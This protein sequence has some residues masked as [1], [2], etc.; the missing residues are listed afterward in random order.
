MSSYCAPCQGIIPWFV[1][2]FKDMKWMSRL[3]GLEPI[4][5]A[6]HQNLSDLESASQAGCP[7]CG[8]IFNL[9]TEVQLKGRICYEGHGAVE[10]LRFCFVL[11][12]P[13][14]LSYEGS[15]PGFSI[16]L[17]FYSP[18]S[19]HQTPIVSTI[20]NHMASHPLNAL[21]EFL[22]P[23]VRNCILNHPDC[24]MKSMEGYLPM[25]LLDVGP[26]DE[27]RDPVLVDS[28]DIRDLD[29]MYLDR[30]DQQPIFYT[31]LSMY[32]NILSFQLRGRDSPWIS[33]YVSCFAKIQ[34]LTTHATFF[35]V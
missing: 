35:Q 6:H 13:P 9:L 19:P 4:E 32:K 15:S 10:S 20:S 22:Q 31:T 28:K 33:R 29:N 5:Y 12:E 7:L 24:G 17:Q 26:G 14:L 18:T 11:D 27:S 25:R 16:D 21:K 8:M 30:N 34:C 2:G 1:N 23:Y 3:Y